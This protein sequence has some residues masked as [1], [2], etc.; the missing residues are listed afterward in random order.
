M[1]AAANEVV[2]KDF[3][4]E[5]QA[6]IEAERARL[7]AEA[8]LRRMREFQRPV[9]RAFTA[10]ERDRV[11]ILF[12]GLTWKHEE[13]IKAVFRGSGYHCENIPTPVVADFQAG[14]EY[15]NNGQ[16]NP[17]YFTVGNLV[18]Y[19]QGLEKQG[20]TRQQIIDN[21]VFF[22]AGSCGPCRFGMYEAEYRYAL[23]NAGFDGFRVLLFQ[24]TD[25]IKAASG[26]P[27]LKF[28]VDFGMGMLNALNLGDVINELAYQIRPFEVNKGDTDRVIQDAVKT[29]TDTLRDR[30]RWH[31]MDAAPDWA[32]PYLEKHRKIEA[33]GCTLG[34][35]GHNLYGKEYVDALHACRDTIDSIQVD[36][37]RV[38]PVIKITGEFWAQTTEGDGNFNMFAFLEREGAQVLVE[39]IATWI[40]Y[41]M[42]VAK[43]G[44]KARAEVE[45]PYKDPKW[46]ELKKQLANELNLFKKTGGLTVGSALWTYFYHRTIK[47][48]GGTVHHLV[49][50]KELARLAHP[51]YH[52]L[53][54]GGEGFMEVGKNVYYTVNHLC[55][56]VLALKPF[57]CMPS[58]QSDG[59]QSRVVNKFKD[60]IFLPIETSGEGE[61][62]AHSRVQMALAEAKAK[63]RAEFQSVLD[64]TGKSLDDLREYVADHPELSRALYHVPHKP[65]VAG[66]AAQFAAHVS[67][68][69]D[70]DRAYRHRARVSIATAN[71][72]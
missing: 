5:I 35:I 48:M 50:Q 57:G 64:K 6:R 8:G 54:R 52:Q 63:A 31:I 37:L 24:Q 69:M 11:T 53:A 46:W 43:E 1:P 29:L 16:C 47:H 62:N 18:R 9:E 40:A 49:P 22:T 51:F 10:E 55:H 34:K 65:G 61:V 36:R 23:Q 20:L 12:G 70:K 67:D 21:Y 33:I 60:M 3:E 32:K 68:L 7:R 41:M 71:A 39:P 72:A 44:A 4:M 13:M 28:S 25:G 66:T 2:Q 27:G 17:T 26:E 56:M 30:K 14:K 45:A 38:K 42:Y 19:L 58:T 15:G 59:V